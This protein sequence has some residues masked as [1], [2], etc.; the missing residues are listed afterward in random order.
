M[1]ETPDGWI[2]RLE[3]D[4]PPNH[5]DACMVCDK[6]DCECPPEPDEAPEWSHKEW[7]AKFRGADCNCGAEPCAMCG[8]TE[9]EIWQ[10]PDRAVEYCAPVQA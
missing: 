3:P 6:I 9:H 8:R 7:C 1:N 4:G 5:E 10:L 2:E